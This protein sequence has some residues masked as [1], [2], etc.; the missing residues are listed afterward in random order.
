MWDLI[1]NIVKLAGIEW[2]QAM[3]WNG[4]SSNSKSK[5]N[6][7]I[8]AGY[9]VIHEFCCLAM[10]KHPESIQPAARLRQV[11]FDFLY[12]AFKQQCTDEISVYRFCDDWKE[13]SF[14]Y[15]VIGLSIDIRISALKI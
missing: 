13:I 10:N 6:N 12:S 8:H 7:I 4:H 11:I 14:L 2:K 5:L 15:K 9:I 3:F 1:A